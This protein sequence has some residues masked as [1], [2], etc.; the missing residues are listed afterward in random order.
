MCYRTGNGNDTFDNDFD[1]VNFF[2]KKNYKIKQSNRGFELTGKLRTLKFN[3]FA[4]YRCIDSCWYILLNGD[5]FKLVEEESRYNGPTKKLRHNQLTLD[6]IRCL[7]D[8][9][10]KKPKVEHEIKSKK[11]RK[12]FKYFNEFDGTEEWYKQD[13]QDLIKEADEGLL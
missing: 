9:P 3:T 7:V 11:L 13:I 8:K 10:F 4:Q 6:E 5:E 2:L 12:L 1:I